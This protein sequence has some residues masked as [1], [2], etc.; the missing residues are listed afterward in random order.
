MRH[1]SR[2]TSTVSFL[3]RRVLTSP[4]A[5]FLVTCPRLPQGLAPADRCALPGA[6]DVAV[7]TA[8]A[9]ANLAVTPGAVVKSGTLFDDRDPVRRGTGQRSQIAVFREWEVAFD[10]RDDPQKARGGQSPGFRI[11]GGGALL[12][13]DC[14]RRKPRTGKLR[15]VKESGAGLRYSTN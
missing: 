2:M 13:P 5:F 11:L 6:V 7:I 4:W 10:D 9:D 15:L 12:H 14:R 1:F 8:P 3:A